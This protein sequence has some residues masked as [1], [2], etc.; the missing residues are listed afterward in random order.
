MKTYFITL[1]RHVLIGVNG[2]T[3]GTRTHL[4]ERLCHTSENTSAEYVQLYIAR[5]GTYADIGRRDAR[6]AVQP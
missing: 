1:R 2:K 3:S 5:D 6:Q 4:Y